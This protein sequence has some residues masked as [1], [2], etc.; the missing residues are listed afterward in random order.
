MERFSAVFL[1]SFGS[2]HIKPPV[3]LDSKPVLSV[4]MCTSFQACSMF[5]QLILTQCS[6]VI[7]VT[8]TIFNKK[9][10]TKGCFLYQTFGHIFINN[11]QQLTL[12]IA[13]PMFQR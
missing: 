12:S 13:T 1:V 10:T 9:S 8:Y 4:T 2:P 6:Y 7:R 3:S 11:D 5:I